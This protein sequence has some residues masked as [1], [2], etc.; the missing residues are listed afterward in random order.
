M[1]HTEQ[2]FSE[3]APTTATMVMTV[4]PQHEAWALKA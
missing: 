3:E 1:A 4:E 2:V